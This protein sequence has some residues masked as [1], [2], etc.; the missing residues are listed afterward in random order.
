MKTSFFNKV[1]K[2]KEYDLDKFRILAENTNIPETILAI[3]FNRGLTTPEEI[4]S[5]LEPQL[6][7]LPS[8]FLMK[9][10]AEASE[11]I[12]QALEEARIVCISGDYD[13]D[14]VTA[15]AVLSLFFREINL[16]VLTFLPDRNLHG[17][18]LNKDSL[19]N[20]YNESLKKGCSSP[21]LISVDCGIAN[22]EEVLA[23]KQMGF[24]VIITDHHQPPG[25]LPDADVV[26]NPLQA[27]CTFPFKHLAGV[28]IAFYLA[29]GVRN[30]LHEKGF[31]NGNRIE[32]TN[33]KKYL[34]LVAIGTIADMVPLIGTNRILAKA[35][36]EILAKPVGVGVKILL[37]KSCGANTQIT[38]ED[39]SFQVCPRIN[40]AGRL[41]NAQIAFDLLTS[42][43][44]YEAEILAIELDQINTERKAIVN[45]ITSRAIAMAD[46]KISKGHSSLVLY[47]PDWHNGVL[48][49]VAS[50]IVNK[51]NRPTIVLSDS[52]GMIKGSGRSIEG[53]NLYKTLLGCTEILHKFGGHE[54]A[55]GL[56]VSANNIL[57]LENLF[58]EAVVAHLNDE[59]IQNPRLLIDNQ[60]DI[61]E[62]MHT[63]FIELYKKIEP[64][65]LGNEEPVFMTNKNV[66]IADTRKVGADSLQFSINENNRQYKA[67]GFGIGSLNETLPKKF[68]RLAYCLRPNT[69]RGIRKWEIRAIDIITNSTP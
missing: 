2:Q 47:D 26:I 57:L 52:G 66:T 4:E 39:I 43:D 44:I 59:E 30:R 1:W 31:W 36:L 6:A 19:Q 10:M 32:A 58:E 62:V 61:A 15:T 35:G 40:A 18:G 68:S 56:S 16:D 53:L 9:G 37:E 55:V 17:Y 11:I 12:I 54:S 7:H 64:F 5:F 34:D 42:D 50:Q 49:I 13:A 21:V 65:G 60:V 14:G 67:F 48:G 46:K 29:M 22:S 23:A 69:F 8:P 28:G 63:G 41:K 45:E 24:T 25:K 51:Y 38:S 27:G 20:L 3:L 33:L